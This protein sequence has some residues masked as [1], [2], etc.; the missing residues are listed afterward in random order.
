MYPSWIVHH[1][2]KYLPDISYI[3]KTA[4]IAEEKGLIDIG[5][6]RLELNQDACSLTIELQMNLLSS[7]HVHDMGTVSAGYSFG[8]SD[9]IWVGFRESKLYVFIRLRKTI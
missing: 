6:N 5:P 1:S 3:L 7:V 9:V 4:E 2:F 8:G